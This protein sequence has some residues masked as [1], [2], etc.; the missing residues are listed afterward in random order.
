MSGRL[1]RMSQDSSRT[2][3]QAGVWSIQQGMSPDAKWK[4]LNCGNQSIEREV[5]T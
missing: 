1:P 4:T 5:Y 3:L 2:S